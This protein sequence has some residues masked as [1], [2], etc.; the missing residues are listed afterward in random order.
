MRAYFAAFGLIAALGVRPLFAAPLEISAS[1]VGDG[2]IL[3]DARGMT[4]YRFDMDKQAGKSACTGDCAKAWPPLPAS[5][6]AKPSPGF[7]VIVRDDGVSQWVHNGKPLYR[8]A[9]DVVPGDENGDGMVFNLWRADFLP[10]STPPGLTI[11]D[12]PLGRV[13]A[14]GQGETLYVSDSDRPGKSN[15][16]SVCADDHT[17]LIAPAIANAVGD[18][19]VVKRDEGA[20]QWA[21]KGRPLYSFISD[22]KPGNVAGEGGGWHAAVLRPIPKLPQ[23]MHYEWSDLGRVVADAD[24]KTYYTLSDSPARLNVCNDACVKA[25][26]RPAAAPSAELHP[27]PGWSTVAL[28]AG[29]QW[30]YKAK[31]IFTFVGD[32]KPGDIRGDRFGNMS[33]GGF[34]PWEVLQP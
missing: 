16:D 29:Y 21:Y 7:S 32:D 2:Q 11:H 18:W 12:S 3:T 27:G 5:Q 25:N 6:D 26:W 9:F 8:Y 19:S 33:S 1:D 15:C 10:I 23:G 4:L 24:G 14:D 34:A 20:K 22:G 13:L 28:G 17:P 31:P 30:T